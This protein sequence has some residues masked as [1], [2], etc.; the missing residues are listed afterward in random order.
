MATYTIAECPEISVTVRGKD[1]PTVR[2]KALD[3]IIELMDA[4]ELPTELPDGLSAEQLIEVQEQPNNNSDI[5]TNEAEEDAVVKAV[6]ELNNLASLKIK[7]GELHQSA[8]KARKDLG[9]LFTDA[10]IEQEVDQLKDLLK[11]SFKILKDFAAASAS[12]KEAKIKAENA[13]AV[14]DEALQFN[15]TKPKLESS[16]DKVD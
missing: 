2:Q 12:Y 6:R 7:V 8:V 10:P 13:R 3:K 4:E 1:S 5:S 16:T 11:G 14:L 9:V 15:E